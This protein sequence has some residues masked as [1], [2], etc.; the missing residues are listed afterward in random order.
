[1][2]LSN[3]WNSIRSLPVSGCS[4]ENFCSRNNRNCLTSSSVGI[5][6]MARRPRLAVLT[7]PDLR[8]SGDG[9]RIAF[10]NADATRAIGRLT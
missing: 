2:S 4:R 8:T 7:K 1:M 6:L 10:P 9:R 3:F 5:F